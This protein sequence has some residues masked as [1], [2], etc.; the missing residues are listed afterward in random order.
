MERNSDNAKML[1]GFLRTI[2]KNVRKVT[3]SDDEL[4]FEANRLNGSL[5]LGLTDQEIRLVIRQYEALEG[6]S[7]PPSTS[8]TNGEGQDWFASFAANEN[9]F[10][11][12]KRYADYLRTTDD[13][14]E[15]TIHQMEI[16][17]KKAISYFANPN[18]PE[19]CLKKGM[20]VG[21]VQAGKTANYI[22]LINMAIDAGYKNIILLAGLSENLRI[23]TQERIDEGFIGA[24]STSFE[25]GDPETFGISIDSNYYGIALTN[26]E[27]DFTSSTA[28]AISAKLGDF[29]KP[30][31]SV[32]KKNSGVITSLNKYI[33]SS[34]D[35]ENLPLLI[36]DDECDNASLNTK[37]EDSPSTINSKIRELASL[38]RI[39]TYVGYSATPFANIFIDPDA[40]YEKNDDTGETTI[41]DLFPSDFIILLEAPNNYLGINQF[42]LGMNKEKTAGYSSNHIIQIGTDL[43]QNF[44]P[45]RHKKQDVYTGLSESLIDAILVFLIDNCVY[46]LRGYGNRHRSMMINISRFNDIQEQIKFYVSQFIDDLKCTVQSSF[47]MPMDAFLN[48]PLM[49]RLYSLWESEDLFRMKNEDG[50]LTKDE[51]SF[52][53]I[54]GVLCDEISKFE[55]HIV[56]GRNKRKERFNYKDREE[57]G[58]RV[59]IIGGFALSRGLTLKGL[60]VSYYNRNA[61]AFD[62]LLQMGRWFGYRPHYSDLVYVF[63]TDKSIAEFCAVSESVEDLK[64]QFRRLAHNPSSTPLDF[65][66]MV[67]EAPETLDTRIMITARNKSKNSETKLFKVSLSGAAVDTSKI[68]KDIHCVQQN[69]E[70]VQELFGRISSEGIQRVNSETMHES[71]K[72]YYKDV[73]AQIIIDLL[74]EGEFS[75]ANG[76]FDAKILSKFIS[77]TPEL[78]K[79]NVVVASG[80]DSGDG[81]QAKTEIFDGISYPRVLRSFTY[82]NNEDFVRIGGSNNRLIDPNIFKVDLSEPE[83]EEAEELAKSELSQGIRKSSTLNVKDYMRAHKKNGLLVIYPIELKVETPNDKNKEE[84]KIKAEIKDALNGECL[85]GFALGFPGSFRRKSTIYR[86]NMVMK[87]RL[88]EGIDEEDSYLDDEDDDL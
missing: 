43:D 87:R 25:N 45:A 76:A 71:G 88:E 36:I 2:F 8:I 34:H 80:L 65:G 40:T 83:L 28:C 69:K 58:A 73:P 47:A 35:R 18:S 55:T 4:R 14:S 64:T 60:M 29:K 20:V 63:M 31:I 75:Y 72:V 16:D 78:R 61:S 57:Q 42:F 70:A 11:H 68:S 85:Y 13:F 49:N 51:F 9:N 67:R 62:V 77:E 22:G 52:E 39:C 38:Y 48:Y 41:P 44:F 17:T 79:W 56:Y 86:I 6:V 19:R 3:P 21:D 66:L 5:R 33:S 23:Q 37:S 59:I 15:Q 30:T 7:M 1:Y 26:I 54:K 74:N 53:Q 24:I 82:E 32:I 84:C 27:H 50:I 10:A 81:T 46:T 12:W